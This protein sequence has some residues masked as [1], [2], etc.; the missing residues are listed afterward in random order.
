MSP[1]DF[2]ELIKK[3]ED[4]TEIAN[5]LFRNKKHT[6]AVEFYEKSLLCSELMMQHVQ[7]AAL[8]DIKVTSRFSQSCNNM[9]KNFMA[10]KEIDKA[11]TY[12]IY[13][14]FHL[15]LLSNK[16]SISESLR[17][18]CIYDWKEAVKA[19]LLFQQK[20]NLPLVINFWQDETYRHLQKAKE[21]IS[22]QNAEMN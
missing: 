4:N 16:E 13:N 1:N 14:I 5:T 11:S 7:E 20:A 12:F 15:K 3:W 9:A 22:M 21:L 8:L 10:N 6:L 18:E 17:N 2:N 19:F